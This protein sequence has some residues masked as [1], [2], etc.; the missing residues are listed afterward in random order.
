VNFEPKSV[1]DSVKKAVPSAIFDF[2]RVTFVLEPVAKLALDFFAVGASTGLAEDALLAL[3]D[4]IAE[5]AKFLGG[6]AFDH[7][8]GDIAEVTRLWVTGKDVEDDGLVS[9]KW[10]VAAF[11]RVASLLAA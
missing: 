1:S 4:G 6:L 9:P 11:V 10:T 7:G 2:G 5:V 8:S 3:N